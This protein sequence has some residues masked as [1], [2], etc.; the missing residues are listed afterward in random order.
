MVTR[1]RELHRRYT[2]ILGIGLG[3]SV[4][5]H[6]AVLGLGR[7]GRV[8]DV[9]HRQL[10]RVEVV[11]RDVTPEE[12]EIRPAESE[13]SAA[14]RP[15]SSYQLTSEELAVAA[16]DLSEARLVLAA[17]TSRDLL[18]PLVPRPRVIP[19][20]EAVGLTPIRVREPLRLATRERGQSGSGGDNGIDG[21]SIFVIGVGGGG[22]CLPAPGVLP[23]RKPLPPARRGTTSTRIGVRG[24]F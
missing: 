16:L 12:N 18:A 8:D 10:S 13:A 7:L 20:R 5:V 9:G 3:I 21:I 4:L 6:G 24:R 2:R 23:L 14:W 1:G 22:V 19:E 17:A 11:A 15:G